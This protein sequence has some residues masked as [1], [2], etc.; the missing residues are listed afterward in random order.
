MQRHLPDTVDLAMPNLSFD[1]PGTIR[2]KLHAPPDKPGRKRRPK[3]QLGRF[4]D[5]GMVPVAEGGSGAVFRVKG[6]DLPKLLDGAV[7]TLVDLPKRGLPEPVV[8]K[9]VKRS[10]SKARSRFLEEIVREA[11]CQASLG[12]QEKLKKHVPTLFACGIF[13]NKYKEDVAVLVM[14]D[15]QAAVPLK[16]HEHLLTPCGLSQIVGIVR[17]LLELGI[18]HADFHFNN[19]LLT[20]TKV[21][22]I[23]FGFAVKLPFSVNPPLRTVNNLFKNE[24]KI[25]RVT[26]AVQW[27][28]WDGRLTHYNPMLRGLRVLLGRAPKHAFNN[29]GRCTSKS[30]TYLRS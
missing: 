4:V 24:S 18:D 15:I 28:R 30:Q 13:V 25:L 12:T 16:G 11:S 1:L 22:L 29:E 8:V 5:S 7:F 21:Y 19:V 9:L 3:F 14:Q 20:K 23:D 2:W 27:K 26:N 6:L 10:Q 17:S